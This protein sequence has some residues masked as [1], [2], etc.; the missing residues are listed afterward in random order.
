M[1]YDVV[2]SMS[3]RSYKPLQI[4]RQ[5]HMKKLAQFIKILGDANR[6]AIINAIGK[7]SL[8]VSEI[9]HATKLSQTLV[10]FHLRALRTAK[11]IK[12]RRDGPFIYNSLAMPELVDL[13]GELSQIADI[14]DNFSRQK[15][16][17]KIAGQK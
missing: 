10:S 16:S 3:T 9:I 1:C 15:T 13:L 6:L 4:S 11:I 2:M 7:N 17:L 5:A 12:T 14:K 8:S